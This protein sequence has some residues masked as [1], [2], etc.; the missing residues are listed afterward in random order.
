MRKWLKPGKHILNAKYHIHF[1]L[2]FIDLMIKLKNH[3]QTGLLEAM[4]K[5][6]Y[7]F[8]K[9]DLIFKIIVSVLQINNLLIFD[10]FGLFCVGYP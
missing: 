5:N 10:T 8:F 4:E 1:K 7:L 6:I 2:G 3:L 9:K